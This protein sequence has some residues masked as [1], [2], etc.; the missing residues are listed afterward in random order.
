[1]VGNGLSTVTLNVT[2]IELFGRIRQPAELA[3]SAGGA[4]DAN[5]LD[6]P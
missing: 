6:T 3:S 5:V 2:V 1:M 4:A